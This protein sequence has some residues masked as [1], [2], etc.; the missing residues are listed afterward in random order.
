[1]LKKR[2]T[3]LSLLAVWYVWFIDWFRVSGVW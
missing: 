2:G 1:M 3:C